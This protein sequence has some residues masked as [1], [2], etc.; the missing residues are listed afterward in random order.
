MEA[1]T[2]GPE[3]FDVTGRR[4]GTRDLANRPVAPKVVGGFLQILD[5]EFDVI[6]I[7]SGAGIA[8]AVIAFVLAAGDT[9]GYYRG[10]Y[11][12][13]DAHGLIKVIA[14]SE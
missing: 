8:H 5:A 7:D 3:E 11:G 13:T 12:I 6:I 10:S 2:E 9:G 4:D 14:N 1:L